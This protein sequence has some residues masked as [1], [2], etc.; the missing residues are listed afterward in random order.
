MA[1]IVIVVHF[2]YHLVHDVVPVDYLIVHDYYV[3]VLHLVENHHH[4]IG[5]ML[6]FKRSKHVGEA[7]QGSGIQAAGRHSR[8]GKKDTKSMV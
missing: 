5:L 6:L 8:H 2:Q 1:I 7:Q 4:M 3:D